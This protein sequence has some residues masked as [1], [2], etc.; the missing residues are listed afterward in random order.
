MLG[1]NK[2]LNDTFIELNS[3]IN[4][5]ENIES[6]NE[7]NDLENINKY[8]ELQK[9]AVASQY[10]A[11]GIGANGIGVNGASYKIDEPVKK[12]N[13]TN[14]CDTNCSKQLLKGPAGILLSEDLTGPKVASISMKI[15]EMKLKCIPLNGDSSNKEN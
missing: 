1:I 6:Q 14:E 13:I 7:I 3:K 4:K 8:N 2:V 10:V 12:D 9:E 5:N 11:V 15:D